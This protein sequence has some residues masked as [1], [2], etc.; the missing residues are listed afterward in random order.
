[1]TVSG[2]ISNRS[3][4]AVWVIPVKHNININK[5]LIP[6]CFWSGWVRF[7]LCGAPIAACGGRKPCP[8]FIA[9]S[10][11]ITPKPP[12]SRMFQIDPPGGLDNRKGRPLRAFYPGISPYGLALSEQILFVI[13]SEGKQS[14]RKWQSTD[15]ASDTKKLLRNKS[16]KG[17]VVNSLFF[18]NKIR[19]GK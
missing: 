16:S 4:N 15:I 10:R 14:E 13:N 1:M 5:L 9:Y 11:I 17:A 18:N 8:R 19:G 3:A 12:Y 7:L 6:E 2:W